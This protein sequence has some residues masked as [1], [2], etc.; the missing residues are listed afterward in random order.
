MAERRVQ[1]GWRTR[2][3]E[4][5]LALHYDDGDDAVLIARPG[6]SQL[7]VVSLNAATGQ[8]LWSASDLGAGSVDLDRVYH[9][10]R[11]PAGGPVLAV[12]SDGLFLR[13]AALSPTDGTLQWT[14]E[15]PHN[16]GSDNLSL[17]T[18]FEV[19]SDGTRAWLAFKSTPPFA[20]L[21]IL[22]AD[23]VAGSVALINDTYNTNTFDIAATPDGSGLAVALGSKDNARVVLLDTATG[24]A[25]WV[26][27]VPSTEH[28]WRPS[29]AIAEQDDLLIAGFGRLGSESGGA[30]IPGARILGL[31]VSQ[32]APLW[33]Q[34]DDSN[35]APLST[36]SE[37]PQVSRIDSATH[38]RTYTLKDAFDQH[39]QILQVADNATGAVLQSQQAV[40]PQNGVL[41]L[42]EL[43]VDGTGR[44]WSHVRLEGANGFSPVSPEYALAHWSADLTSAYEALPVQ[45]SVVQQG[46]FKVTAYH[47]ATRS[48]A[49]LEAS[50]SQE[51]PRLL[52]THA[53]TGNVLLDATLPAGP[54]SSFTRYA[55][56]FSQFGQHIAVRSQ[57]NTVV[58]RLWAYSLT[59]NSLLWFR[60][61]DFD[62]QVGV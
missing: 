1:R 37:G 10:A 8:P 7:E 2:R 44:A 6:E 40:G 27:T 18:Q 62:L 22:E 52:V 54:G 9:L 45:D 55:L 56:E 24:V 57:G 16:L 38:L 58:N 21:K 34:V 49:L 48:V 28:T 29:V 35:T 13:F 36:L 41:H 26:H 46:D 32:G 25:Q 50:A 14:A 30:G 43:G 51:L 23:L 47:A 19:S 12:V 11:V 31:S 42:E 4:L 59:T 17:V 60:D 53:D 3:G 5:R 39:V 20:L 15:I 61:I 33:T